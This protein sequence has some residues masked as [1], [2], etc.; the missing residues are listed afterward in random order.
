MKVLVPVKRVVDFNVKVRV[1]PDGSGVAARDEVLAG[2]VGPPLGV[3]LPEPST[4]R[5][6]GR[7][8]W[9]A[10]AGEYRPPPNRLDLR[11]LQ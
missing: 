10:T 7:L 6:W 2:L 1:R 9:F 11:P 8:G 4:R 5:F 3:T